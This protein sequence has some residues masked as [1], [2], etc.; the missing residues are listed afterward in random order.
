[1]E[2]EPVALAQ[3]EIKVGE[4]LVLSGFIPEHPWSWREKRRFIETSVLAEAHQG[5]EFQ[6][7]PSMLS[8]DEGNRGGPCLRETARGVEV[9]GISSGYRDGSPS[10]TSI[11]PYRTWL[12]GE[13]QNAASAKAVQPESSPDEPSIVDPEDP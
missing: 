8:L 7:E 9:V 1:M 13:I 5:P 10:C 2:V 11:L 6:V 3:D 4:T 12:A